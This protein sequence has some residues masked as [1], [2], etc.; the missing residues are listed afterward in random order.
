MKKSLLKEILSF[1][2][3]AIFIYLCFLPQLNTVFEE[4]DSAAAT[5]GFSWQWGSGC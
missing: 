3:T 4:K 1:S 5:L 2:L